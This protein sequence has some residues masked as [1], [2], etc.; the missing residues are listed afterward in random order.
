MAFSPAQEA[1]FRTLVKAAYAA[2]LVAGR[3]NPKAIFDF[4]RSIATDLGVKLAAVVLRLFSLW[5][6][7]VIY[8]V[9]KLADMD[10]LK[11]PSRIESAIQ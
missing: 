3:L 9:G 4:L 1:L 8:F 6:L 10:L 2:P 11:Q 5:Y 7:I